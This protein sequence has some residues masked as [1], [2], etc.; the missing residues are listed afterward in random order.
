MDHRADYIEVLLI[1]DSPADARLTQEAFKEGTIRNNLTVL[2]DGVEA[3]KYLHREGRYA[4]APRPDLILLDLNLPKMHG[5]DV[6]KRI[7]TDAHLSRIPVVVLT[8][9][10]DEQ[11]VLDAYD[12]HANCYLRKPVD[13]ENFLRIVSSIEAFWLTA[14]R[15]PSNS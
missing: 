1:E 13:L 10:H 8:T 7:K 5:K 4:H 2:S 6:L 14:V 3:M 11:D 9:S 15:L 12:R